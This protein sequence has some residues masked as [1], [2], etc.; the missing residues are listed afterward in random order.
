MRPHPVVIKDA[1]RALPKTLDET[2]ER[3]FSEVPDDDRCFTRHVLHWI[4]FHQFLHADGLPLGSTVLLAAAGR[5]MDME[6]D[7]NNEF[8]HDIQRLRD[9][10]GCLIHVDQDDAVRFAHYT[11]REYLDSPRMA[12]SA[13]SY[14]CSGSTI[15]DSLCVQIVLEDAQAVDESLLAKTEAEGK[16]LDLYRL[17][18]EHYSAY[19][20]IT[21]LAL[22]LKAPAAIASDSKS[23]SL[24]AALFNPKSEHYTEMSKISQAAENHGD[25]SFMD[26]CDIIPRWRHMPENSDAAIFLQFILCGR[27]LNPSQTTLASAFKLDKDVQNSKSELSFCLYSREEIGLQIGD[28]EYDFSGSLLT[29]VAELSYLENGPLLW[30]LDQ[31]EELDEPQVFPPV[32]AYHR[33]CEQCYPSAT[34]KGA[35]CL[36]RLVLDRLEGVA[37]EQW[38]VTPLQLVVSMGDVRGVQILLE[39]GADPNG[40]GDTDGDPFGDEHILKWYNGLNGNWP[41]RICC[42]EHLRYRR[43]GYYEDDFRG[44]KALLLWY[45]ATDDDD[46]T[47]NSIEETGDE[48]HENLE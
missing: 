11:V 6:P 44:I 15:L 9:V 26:L 42:T 20:V 16:N 41:T 23:L 3:I 37:D 31:C 24:A 47:E 48:D 8:E 18:S 28:D 19:C 21:S 25:D 45:G 40:A 7:F 46:H 34:S 13:V 35:P 43:G 14:F 36:L 32:A 4:C 2:Y 27:K 12:K 17:F 5:S 10:L 1:L 33:R 38:F 39:A 29:I 22:L 30:M